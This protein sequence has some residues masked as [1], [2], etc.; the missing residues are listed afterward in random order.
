MTPSKKDDQDKQ[1]RTKRAKTEGSKPRARAAAPKSAAK[2]K[3]ARKA[4]AT[5]GAAAP[6]TTGRARVKRVKPGSVEHAAPSDAETLFAPP[7]PSP[8]ESKPA[9]PP[10]VASNDD[11]LAEWAAPEIERPRPRLRNVPPK[12]A[13]PI[14]P[15]GADHRPQSQDASKLLDIPAWPELTDEPVEPKPRL[16]P[17]P[18]PRPAQPRPLPPQPIARPPRDVARD[19]NAR[20]TAGGPRSDRPVEPSLGNDDEPLDASDREGDQPMPGTD[21][22][23]QPT[24]RRR[25]RR[26]GRNRGQRQDQPQL[27]DAAEPGTQ[28]PPPPPQAQPPRGG[29]PRDGQR[30][31]RP[32]NDQR[33]DRPRQERPP[34]ERPPQERTPQEHPRENQP[35]QE[36]PRGDHRRGDRPA[37]DPR[38]SDRPRGDQPRRDQRPQGDRAPAPRRDE[39]PEELEPKTIVLPPAEPLDVELDAVDQAWIDDEDVT[40]PKPDDKNG[41][42][43]LINVAE[44]EECRI[45]ILHQ[46]HLEELFIERASAESHVG[47]IY[48]GR[49]TNVEPSIQAAFVDFG[50]PKNGFLHISDLQPQ[51]FPGGSKMLEEVGRKT[52]RRDRPP[53][54]KCLRRGQEVI[55]QIIK[56]GIGTKGPTLTTYI[57]IP[58]RYL[59][60]MPGMNRLGVSRRIEDDDARRKMRAI[61]DEL[62]LPKEMGFILRTA[63]LDRTKREIQQDLLY[64]QR[65]WKVVARRIKND[66][67]PCE[68]YRESDLV[69]RTIRDV[70]SS[71]FSRIIV[72]DERTA[73]KVRDFLAIAMPRSSAPVEFYSGARPLFHEYKLEQEID[74]INSR[75]VP[76]QSGGSLVIE[77]TEA[78]VAIDVNSGRFRDHDDAEE[79]AFRINIEAAEEIA[80]QLRLRDLGGLIL[81]DFVDMR[82][83]K[84]RRGVERALRDAL[85]KHKERA[86]CLRM[87]QFGIIEM[88]RQRMRP[89]IKRS[90]YQDCPHCRGV[91]LVKNSESMTLDVMR[92]LRVATHHEAVEIVEVRV[93][94]DVAF[95]LQN[96]KRTAIHA[97][98]VETHRQIIIRADENLGPDQHSF[99]CLD[100]RGGTIRMEDMPEAVR[101]AGEIRSKRKSGP[102]SDHVIENPR[103][104]LEDVF[105]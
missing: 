43:M 48:K 53:I 26:R 13:R 86:K 76:L 69:I 104:T 44:G 34:Q 84:H 18:P 46:S 74:R 105:D 102:L 75:Y 19:Q 98:E 16:A 29:P 73:E 50:L 60:M 100:Q 89:S 39:F 27:N 90:I 93:A 23:P 67:A 15:A 52:P 66:R 24:K 5:Q 61:L 97:L 57:S 92:L 91:G 37:N 7:A 28:G 31:D 21:E 20:P 81:C 47:N 59:V 35:R 95:Q 11:P 45:A 49:V 79:T 42:V 8:T 87:S 41:R 30:Q 72:D 17:P 85:K 9:A 40:M 62:E 64:L 56:E 83:E 22:T 58:G 101:N 99:E 38:R 96:R 1:E 33:S 71:D 103:E 77:S 54:Q 51:Y 14:E 88:T 65:L 68:L 3:P 63:G 32:R 10:I 4:A 2:P 82:A 80:R 36:R 78:L 55:V 25:R 6:K 94:P 70:F 12:P